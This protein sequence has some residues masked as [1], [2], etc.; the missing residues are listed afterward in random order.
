V[1]KRVL[2]TLGLWS[3]LFV[4]LW[5]FRTAG[6]VTL[7]AV[8]TGLTLREF[9]QLQTAAGR[10]PFPLFGIFFG[11]LIAVAPWIEAQYGRPAH[12]LIPL[13]VVILAIWILGERPPE[14][15]VDALSSTIFGLV[16]VAVML[17]YLVRIMTPLPGDT[18]S[19]DGR[20][21]L[22]IWLVAVAK[23]CDTGALLTGMARGRH[24]MAPQISPKKTWEGAVGGVVIASLVGAG[25]AWLGR[26]QIGAVLPPGKAAVI[27]IPIAIVAIVSD[28]V[29]SII[30]RQAA[31]K[32]S[33]K[34]IPGIGGIFDVMDSILLVAPVG[35]FLLGVK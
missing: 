23:F 20:L 14:Q 21:I 17:Q 26:Q 3:I 13:A 9:Y 29:E 34:A 16:Y 11:M 35:Y 30:K 24:A 25:I 1:G 5:F 33:G 6:A 7:L 31:I 28:L 2:S 18:L 32:D 10:A 4:T 27:A 12:P 8:L 19:A 22:C 15:R